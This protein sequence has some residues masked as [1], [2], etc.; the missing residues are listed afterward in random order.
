MNW[1][2][3]NSHLKK[4][5]LNINNNNDQSPLK[6]TLKFGSN[7]RECNIFFIIIAYRKPAQTKSVQSLRLREHL[8]N[9]I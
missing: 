8:K 7:I 6:S 2:P 3:V 1:K 9:S 4:N 5:I